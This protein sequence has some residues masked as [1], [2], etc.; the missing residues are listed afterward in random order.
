MSVS[1]RGKDPTALLTAHYVI[2]KSCPAVHVISF[3]WIGLLFFYE[4]VE[5]HTRTYKNMCVY[6]HICLPYVAGK[7]L[8]GLNNL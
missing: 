4:C 8:S 2:K 6:I 5:V 1:L 7:V 3:G